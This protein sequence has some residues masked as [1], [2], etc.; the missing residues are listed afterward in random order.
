MKPL[1]KKLTNTSDKYSGSLENT[2]WN[3]NNT[4]S[5]K[6]IFEFGMYPNGNAHFHEGTT[7]IKN[8]F[9]Y[10]EYGASFWVIL[11]DENNP[12]AFT[13]YE[14]SFGGGSG[15]GKFVLGTESTTIITHFTMNKVA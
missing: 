3:I 14:G 13:M 10:Y 9:K 7:I 2:N 11:N 1:I 12:N 6:I 8:P 15:S 5:E 4:N